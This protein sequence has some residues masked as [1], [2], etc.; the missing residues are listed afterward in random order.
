MANL[1]VILANNGDWEAAENLGLEVLMMRRQILG[2]LHDHKHVSSRNL[3]AFYQN[4]AKYEQAED[5]YLEEL[6]KMPE[7]DSRRLDFMAGLASIYKCQGRYGEAEAQARRVLESRARSSEA[8]DPILLAS[9]HDL[10]TILAE[11]AQYDEAKVLCAEVMRARR[12]VLGTKHRDTLAATAKLMEAVQVLSRVVAMM[13]QAGAPHNCI[14][15]V[16]ANLAMALSNVGR[17]KEAEELQ[18]QLVDTRKH[19][20]GEEHLATLNC[21]T[22]LTATYRFQGRYAEAERLKS[23][24]LGSREKLLGR[25]HPDTLA[26]KASLALTYNL[27]GRYEEA[28]DIGEA[29]GATTKRVL[30]EK[31]IDTLT[32][33]GNLALTYHHLQRHLEAEALEVQVLKANYETLGEKHPQTLASMN[34]L[35]SSYIETGR[36][37]EAKVLATDLLIRGRGFLAITRRQC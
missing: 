25:E 17:H 8:D 23:W 28:K 37:D 3:A 1:S 16:K 7:G 22:G 2:E 13:N 18:L 35:A 15:S 19:A 29:L 31:H 12:R 24:V 33:L 30:G 27:R 32:A 6:G 20:F 34:N 11:Q 10:A 21:M 9:K 5:L 4:R 14:L 36:V 26:I